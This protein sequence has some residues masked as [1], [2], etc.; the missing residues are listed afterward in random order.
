MD[1]RD[2]YEPT[3]ARIDADDLEHGEVGESDGG[4]A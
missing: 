1:S 3:T 4:E 2:S